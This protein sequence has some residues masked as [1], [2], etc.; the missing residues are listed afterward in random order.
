MRKVSKKR[1][2]LL[3][4]AQPWRE[5]MVREVGRCEWCG[6]YFSLA[7]HEISRGNA[8]A[9]SLTCR[10]VILI[11]C[12]APHGTKPSCHD[13]VGLWPRA[14]QL[15]LLYHV[16]TSDYNLDVY[17]QKVGHKSPSQEEVDVHIEEIINARRCGR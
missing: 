11:L 16:R 6:R 8:R 17:H 14:R 1:A 15:A 3:E 12:N 9:A 10:S 4:T 5:E 13:V 2:K 7:P